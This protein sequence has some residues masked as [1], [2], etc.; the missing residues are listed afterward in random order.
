MARFASTASPEDRR[1]FGAW[2]ED[3]RRRKGLSNQKLTEALG[4]SR[5][6][7]G[8]R[9]GF[10]SRYFTG[11][12]QPTAEKLRI[13]AEALDISPTEALLR[14]GHA[15]ELFGDFVRLEKLGLAWCEEDGAEIQPSAD[16]RSSRGFIEAV[17]EVKTR[18]TRAGQV[19]EITR[20]SHFVYGDRINKL[21]SYFN[22]RGGHTYANR[23]YVEVSLDE[24]GLP[25][26]V[27]VPKPFAC[28]IQLALAS[29]PA[30][31]FRRSSHVYE[32]VASLINDVDSLLG[33]ARILLKER[34]E[35]ARL[36]LLLDRA[37]K[38]IGDPKLP[39]AVREAVS[40]E[41]V[42]AWCDNLSPDYADYARRTL[43]E[44]KT[45]GNLSF[46]DESSIDSAPDKR[47]DPRKA[48][49]GRMR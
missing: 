35:R 31:F 13:L 39:S 10:L 40:A 42:G 14:A 8:G 18:K 1:H 34:G 2:L 29:L 25:Q 4:W 41:Y 7:T 17:H 22:D 15:K 24:P 5:A 49:R 9:S 43:W 37:A 44:T 3:A 28:A 46:T 16:G 45:I 20:D 26:I 48:F 38:A 11:E 21:G 32:N 27:V 30:H 33:D 47:S 23:R 12:S 36:P 6:G 19:N